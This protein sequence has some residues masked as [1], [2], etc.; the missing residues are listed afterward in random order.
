MAGD[1]EGWSPRRVWGPGA[2]WRAGGG[3]GWACTWGARVV[4][5]RW[6]VTPPRPPS[7]REG[8]GILS[9][10]VQAGMFVIYIYTVLL[11]I[12]GRN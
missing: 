10:A 9:H 7:Q 4:T 3:P 11:Y 8:G 1:D 2:A 5:A 12:D 6:S